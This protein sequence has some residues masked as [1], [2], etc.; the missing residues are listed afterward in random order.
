MRVRAIVRAFALISPLLCAIA[1]ADPAGEPG[2]FER[3]PGEVGQQFYR[4]KAEGW[5]WHEDYAQPKPKKKKVEEPKPVVPVA[6]AKAEVP[7]A[8]AGPTPLSVAWIRENLPKVRDQ[9][10][11]TG[12]PEDV[13]AYYYLQRVMMDKSQK[14][15]E[16]STDV[17]RTDPMLDEDTRRPVGTFAANAMTTMAGEKRSALLKEISKRAGFYFFFDSACGLCAAQANVVEMLASRTGLPVIPVSLD[18]KPMNGSTLYKNFRPDQGQAAALGVTQTPALALGMPA[19]GEV[20]IVSFGVV[21]LDV[22][23]NRVLLAARD[24]GLITP[25]QYENTRPIQNNGLF[26]G[27]AIAGVDAEKAK[28]DPAEFVQML[29]ERFAQSGDTQR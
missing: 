26:T 28:T 15:A 24:G 6:E 20:K 23:E 5:F 16:T 3:D 12:K 27:D 14:F 29:R 1:E 17:I 7:A 2:A 25:A 4:A 13:R 19:T 21:A 9:A 22:L 8:P 11:D 18:G 10:I